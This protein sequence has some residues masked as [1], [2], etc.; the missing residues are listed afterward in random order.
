MAPWIDFEKIK[1]EADFATVLRH[2]GFEFP[3]GRTQLKLRC[4]FHEDGTPSLSV[5]LAEKVWH[6]FGCGERGNVL[7]F[8]ECMEALGDKRPSTRQAAV[9]VAAICGL[10]S[11]KA[12]GPAR[13][14]RRSSC[15]PRSS[16]MRWTPT[17]TAAATSS[18]TPPT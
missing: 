3:E 18:T 8:V 17:A 10:T 16:A 6:C 5:N 13:S 15:R 9:R 2:Y 7:R 11:S 4:P 14:G 1:R 12:P